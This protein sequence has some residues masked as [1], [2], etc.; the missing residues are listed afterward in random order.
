MNANK[1]KVVITSIGVSSPIG[2]DLSH[3]AKNYD[4]SSEVATSHID[5][6]KL[7][8]ELGQFKKVNQRRMDRLTKIT[9]MSAITCLEDAKI[10]IDESTIND[11]GGIFCTAYGPIAS[12][13]DF[14]NSGFELG[15]DSASPLLFPYTVGNAAPG[16]IT[17]LMKSRGYNTTVSGYNPIAY[18]FDVIRQK[19]AKA[20]LAGGFEE[21]SPEVEAAYNT[22]TIVNGNGLKKQASVSLMSEGAVM[23]F[24]EDAEFA[25]ARN[26]E[27][28]FEVCGYGV[29]SNLQREE[30][31]ID[32]FGYIA[33][34]SILNSMKT[35]LVRSEVAGANI[36]L[37]ISL[38]REDSRQTE[39]EVEAIKQ[40]WPEN[41]PEVHYVKQVLGETFGASDGF[42]A[43]AG[44]VKAKKIKGTDQNKKHVMVNSYHIGGNC[45]SMIIAV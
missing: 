1:S 26:A 12:A 13:R 8:E 36:D 40:L 34:Q 33:P 39:S 22:R 28:L 23:M 4:Q 38:S 25:K 19:K 27:V 37:I 11:V 45:F 16:A 32:N 9:M 2:N 20:I 29:N 7:E 30:K 3:F 35:S 14:I 10:E 41:T 31:S 24:V 42:A 15:L 18:A 43:V 5:D 21:L 44:Y 17:V 6:T